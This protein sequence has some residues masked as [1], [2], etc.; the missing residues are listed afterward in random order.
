MHRN[1]QRRSC[2]QLLVVQITGVDSWRRAVHLAR[3]F[4]RRDAHAS[5]EWF[6]RNVD[7]S[8]KMS[9]VTLPVQRNYLRPALREYIREKTCASEAVVRIRNIQ[10]D[11]AN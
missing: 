10:P 5:K 8:A 6:Q 11:L 2:H 9:D 3:G 4:R 7:P 1:E